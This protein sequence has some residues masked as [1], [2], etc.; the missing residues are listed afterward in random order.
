LFRALSLPHEVMEQKPL[1]F[2]S[3]PHRLERAGAGSAS[4]PLDSPRGA[5]LFSIYR[6]TTRAASSIFLR[7]VVSFMKSDF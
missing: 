4:I 2:S 5:V 7:M 6:K 1:C 3:P